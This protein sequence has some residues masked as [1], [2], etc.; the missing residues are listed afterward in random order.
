[1]SEEPTAKRRLLGRIGALFEKTTKSIWLILTRPYIAVIVIFS[2]ILAVYFL[3]GVSLVGK[4]SLMLFCQR[5]SLLEKEAEAVLISEGINVSQPPRVYILT[6]SFK[7]FFSMPYAFSYK[8][9]FPG[10]YKDQIKQSYSVVEDNAIVIQENDENQRWVLIH[11][12]GHLV[13]YYS[14][15]AGYTQKSF[16]ERENSATFFANK[17]ERKIHLKIK[18]Q[19]S[20]G[21]PR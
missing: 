15:P 5:S 9:A 1:M 17:V 8:K 16:Q 18:Q 3:M 21:R 11:E 2:S 19:G 20:R 12:V 4:P 6:E 13:D 14:D 10:Q 7:N